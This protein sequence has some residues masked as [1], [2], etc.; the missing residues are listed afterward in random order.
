[1]FL[2]VQRQ[3]KHSSLIKS[4]DELSILQIMLC[5]IHICMELVDV[6]CG[7]KKEQ[8]IQRMNPDAEI[9]PILATCTH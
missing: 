5:E 9:L 2:P 8:N 3:R 4:V 6:T 1:M 7:G